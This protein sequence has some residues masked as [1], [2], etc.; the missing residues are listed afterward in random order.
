MGPPWVQGLFA[1]WKIIVTE[2][3]HS[4]LSS[5]EVRNAWGYNNASMACKWTILPP[6]SLQRLDESLQCRL[7]NA[8]SC[9]RVAIIL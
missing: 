1:S 6:A 5:T 4:P 9:N 8:H 2:V 7:K 3:I